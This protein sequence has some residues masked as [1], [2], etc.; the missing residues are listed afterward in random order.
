MASALTSYLFATLFFALAIQTP[1]KTPRSTLSILHVIATLHTLTSPIPHLGPY[2]HLWPSFVIWSTLHTISI[3]F[4]ERGRVTYVSATTLEDRLAS[5]FWLWS[6]IRRVPIAPPKARPSSSSSREDEYRAR[7]RFGIT[8]FVHL[9]VLVGAHYA[10]NTFITTTVRNIHLRAADFAPEK[11]ALLPASLSPRDLYLRTIISSHWIWST[12][13]LLTAAHNVLSILSV[14]LFGWS[15]PAE[16]PPLFGSPGA[17]YSLRRFWAVFWQGLHRAPFAAF[18]PVWLRGKNKKKNSRWH[19]NA[20]R[21]LWMFVL[22]ALCHAL[23]D[24]VQ[25]RRNLLA[26]ELGFFLTN[27]VVACLETAVGGWIGRRLKKQGMSEEARRGLGYLW[28]GL[29]FFCMVPAWKYPL[30]QAY[31]G[32]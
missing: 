21:A 6:N 31:L 11:Q 25:T 1:L 14:T 19:W 12:Y 16:W 3:L 24:F 10:I 17:A 5:T 13:S 27:Y 4:F 7:A 22:S 29:F 28:V 32:M 9:L 2:Y 30:L 15:Q 20:L 18:M 26:Q 8:K 23:V